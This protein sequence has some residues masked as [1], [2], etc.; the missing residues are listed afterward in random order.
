V[1]EDEERVRRAVVQIL[2]RA[3]YRTL[4][5]ENGL[6]AIRLLRE[7]EGRVH[8]VFL[9]V[10]M[11]ELGG[12]ETWE[13]MQKVRDGLRVL[14]TSGYAGDQS[15]EQLPPDAEVLAKPFRSEELLSRIRKKLDDG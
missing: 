14:F 4:A 12:P 10:V 6:E 13:R 2:E 7:H 11:P 5:A 8:L 15:R 9:D 1:V 3:G